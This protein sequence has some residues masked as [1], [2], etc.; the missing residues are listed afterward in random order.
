MNLK[1]KRGQAVVEMA[2]VLPIFLMIILGIFDFGRAMHAWGTLNYQ[3]VRAAR[4]ATIRTIPSLRGYGVNTHTS[5]EDVDRVFWAFRSPMM[6][7]DDYDNSVVFRGVGVGTDTVEIS[8]SY[9]LTLVTPVIGTMVGGSESSGILTIN[10][11][12]RENKE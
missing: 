1:S 5:Y 11:I 4:A 6:A 9:K 8:A 12:A 7:K 10:A 2:L 3:C